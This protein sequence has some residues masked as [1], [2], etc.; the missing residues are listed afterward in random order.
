MSKPKYRSGDEI[1]LHDQVLFEGKDGIIELIVTTN[2]D[3]WDSYW[4][5][6]GEGVMVKCEGFGRIFVPFDDEGLE[7]KHRAPS[8]KLDLD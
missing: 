1:V 4:H 7:L 3:D 8:V 5:E 6:Q 2:D